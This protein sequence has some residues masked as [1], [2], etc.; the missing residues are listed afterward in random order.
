MSNNRLWLVVPIVDE[1]EPRRVLLAK[2][3]SSGWDLWQP[4]TLIERLEAALDGA[5]IAAT[6]VGDATTITLVD[7]NGL[8]AEQIEEMTL[9]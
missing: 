8:T 5:D 2:G 4:E 6:T 3:W 1:D 9:P 7:E